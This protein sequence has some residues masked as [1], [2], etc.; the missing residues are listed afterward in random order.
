MIR[1]QTWGTGFESQIPGRSIACLSSPLVLALQ[2]QARCLRPP[3][4]P[5]LEPQVQ[6]TARVGKHSL[7][8]QACSSQPLASEASQ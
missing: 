4:L 3:G 6:V 5:V 1:M 2:V 7:G 8:L